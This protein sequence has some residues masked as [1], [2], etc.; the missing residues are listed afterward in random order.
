VRSALIRINK[1]VHWFRHQRRAADPVRE[2][3]PDLIG[4][5]P[6]TLAHHA[7]RRAWL[8]LGFFDNDAVVRMRLAIDACISRQKGAYSQC[9]PRHV[10]RSAYCAATQ[11][12]KTLYGPCIA[13]FTN[14]DL[15][16]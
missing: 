14:C 10:I 3:C 1:L 5:S 16:Q 13:K 4:S 8:T 6:V 7:R 15:A 12:M 9:L 2:R 11:V